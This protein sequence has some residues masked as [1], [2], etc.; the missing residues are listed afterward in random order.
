[1][2]GWQKVKCLSCITAESRLKVSQQKH[3]NS[4]SREDEASEDCGDPLTFLLAALIKSNVS[5]AFKTQLKFFVFS[6][7]VANVSLLSQQTKMVN[8]MKV[9]VCRWRSL[10]EL[11]PDLLEELRHSNSISSQIKPGPSLSEHHKCCRC[12]K[13]NHSKHW[14][15]G[16]IFPLI[17]YLLLQITV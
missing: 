10:H 6:A 3:R 2:D 11:K 13:H 1:M 17:T 4:W 12:S 7:N 15:N 8:N 5:S 9:L 16:V 14:Y